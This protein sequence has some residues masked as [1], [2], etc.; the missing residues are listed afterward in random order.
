MIKTVKDYKE[1]MD[2]MKNDPEYVVKYRSEQD[3]VI[4][5]H[6]LELK[7]FNK[8]ED[9]PEIPVKPIEE[10]RDFYFPILIKCGAIPK[11]DLVDGEWYYGEHRRCTVAKWDEKDNKFKYWR[12]KFNS[13]Y[14]D[15]CKHFEDDDGYAVFVP[16][17][18]ATNEEIP[19]L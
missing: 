18:K 1:H 16:L 3:A 13:N 4:R 7:P 6:W 14:W 11:K 10:L 12:Q 9:I 5:K 15:I 19:I 17:R 2:K 8:A